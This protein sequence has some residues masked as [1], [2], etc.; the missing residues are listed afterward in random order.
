MIGNREDQEEMAHF[1]LMRDFIPDDHILKLVDKH[2]DLTFVRERLRPFYSERGRPSV[3]PEIM[4]RMLL[5]GYLF[6]ITSERRLCE[7]VSMHIGY[8][9]FVGL[10]MR[11]RTPDHSTFSKNRH[12]RFRDSGV[13]EEVFDEVVRRCIAAGLVSGGRLSADGTLVEANASTK[14]LTPFVVELSP[15]AYLREVERGNAVSETSVEDGKETRE[16][17]KVSNDTH[18]SRTDGDARIAKKGGF[19]TGLYYQVS[20]TMDNA[21]RVILDARV[22]AP[23]P[24]T[25]M[26]DALAGLDRAMWRFKCPAET[27]GLDGNY[28]SAD[29]LHDVMERGVTPY[30]PLRHMGEVNA[31][32]RGVWPRERFTYDAGRDCYLCPRGKVLKSRGLSG[33]QRAY[34][35]SVKDCGS[36]PVKSDCTRDKSRT[37]CIHINNDALEQTLKRMGTK[38]YRL[39]HKERKRIESLF[40]EAKE[41]MGL[42]RMKFRGRDTVTEQVLLT[43]IAQNIKRLVRHLDRLSSRPAKALRSM[44]QSA[45]ETVWDALRRLIALCFTPCAHRHH[46]PEGAR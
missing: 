30:V 31:A 32:A 3:D 40:G 7:E 34:R 45:K 29:F 1:F 24:G 5:V 15:A 20:Y 4:V 25:E 44:T 28:R 37:V 23:G 26:A 10:R 2:V 13:W 46:L 6:G 11:D 12:G 33:R 27:L 9:W 42:R 39:S 38:E 41:Q 36:C 14:S 43:A 19:P 18:R 17:R 16:K 35:A 22:S 8:R 21:S